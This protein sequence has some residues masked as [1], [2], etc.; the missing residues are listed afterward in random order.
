MTDRDAQ[1]ARVYAAESFVHTVFERAD[2]H[3]CRS[4]DFFGTALTLPPEARFASTEAVQRYVDRVLELPAVAN[5]WTVGPVRVR[6]R[7]G[8]TRAHYEVVDGVGVIAVPDRPDDDGSRWAMRELVV[9]H[10]IAHHL[11]P[12][13]PPHGPDFVATFC[14]L[15]GHVMGP[16]A[17]HVLRV[18]YAKE[19]VR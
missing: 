17:G 2:Q 3:G 7:R 15:A 18:I 14:E 10:E 9:L 13:G 4:I 19:G 8:I 6:G 12:G 5:T 11:T 16:E 1:R